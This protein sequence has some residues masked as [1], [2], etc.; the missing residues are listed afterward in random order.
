MHLSRCSCTFAHV[1]CYEKDDESIDVDELVSIV[2]YY[3]YPASF[4]LRS[5]VSI[6]TNDTY[7]SRIASM[8]EQCMQLC[9]THTA[10]N[11]FIAFSDETGHI[12]AYTGSNA[13]PYN[14]S[15]HFF[16]RVCKDMTQKEQRPHVDLGKVRSSLR[17][18]DNMKPVMLA[19]EQSGKLGA[20]TAYR[21]ALD[22]IAAQVK[23]YKN[24]CFMRSQSTNDGLDFCN[25]CV[26]LFVLCNKPFINANVLILVIV[27]ELARRRIDGAKERHL[28]RQQLTFCACDNGPSKDAQCAQ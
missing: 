7:S 18:A 14:P 25:G 16:N 1:S 13:A 5:G 24:K 15:F 26:V 11:F 27:N 23:E 17:T 10:S 28:C 3:K 2:H 8:K 22:L 20:S 6:P 19:Y 9:A 12:H 4:W 21:K